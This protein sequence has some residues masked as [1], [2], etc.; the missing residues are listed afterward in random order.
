MR[1]RERCVPKAESSLLVFSAR[2]ENKKGARGRRKRNEEQEEGR[3]RGLVAGGKALSKGKAG[4]RK[5]RKEA[6]KEKTGG[7]S[8]ERKGHKTEGPGTRQQCEQ[9]GNSR[10]IWG[11]Q[12]SRK[13]WQKKKEKHGKQETQAKIGTIGA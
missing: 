12:G 3:K 7:K 1:G 8:K 9:L 13:R 11:Y 5:D 2:F 10:K 6:R 4:C